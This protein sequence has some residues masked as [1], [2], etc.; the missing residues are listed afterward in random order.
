M[1][2]WA[3]VNIQYTVACTDCLR[4]ILIK[5]QATH[6]SDLHRHPHPHHYKHRNSPSAP[7]HDTTTRFLL[8]KIFTKNQR[9]TNKN[10]SYSPETDHITETGTPRIQYLIFST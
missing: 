1:P 9:V 8:K 3:E 4:G 2:P 6:L 5:S 7:Y 10:S